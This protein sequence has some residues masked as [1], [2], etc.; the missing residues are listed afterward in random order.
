MG[1]VTRATASQN[2]E[3]EGFAGSYRDI[4]GWTVGFETYLAHA[5]LAPYFKGLPDDACQAVHIGYVLRGKLVWHYTDGT[6]EVT[7]SGAAYV[8]KPGHTP[9][10]FPDTEVVEFTRADEL[11][12]TMA[13]VEKNMAEMG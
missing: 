3:F 13:V 11:A 1:I 8:T 4:E 12:A 5:D 9:E 6:T 10:L 7:E 2:V